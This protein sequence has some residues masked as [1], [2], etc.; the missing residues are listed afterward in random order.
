MSN[1]TRKLRRIGKLK[2]ASMEVLKN[3]NPERLVG[4]AIMRDG[5]LHSGFREHWRIRAAIGDEDPSR[6]NPDDQEGFLAAPERVGT[7]GRFVSRQ[8]A[9]IIGVNSGQLNPMWLHATRD[10]LSSDINW[11]A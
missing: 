9:R 11:D 2:I 7:E 1:L 3:P 4:A 10:V 6:K 8:E 5:K